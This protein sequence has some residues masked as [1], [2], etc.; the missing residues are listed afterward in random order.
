MHRSALLLASLLLAAPVRAQQLEPRA[1]S[2]VP[3]G[4]NIA[5]LGYGRSTGQLLFGQDIPIEN[6]SATVNTLTDSEVA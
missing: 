1:F 4:L 2:V 3:V 5:A 6:A